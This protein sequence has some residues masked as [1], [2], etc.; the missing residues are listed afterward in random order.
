MR[1]LWFYLLAE[2]RTFV[3]R[4]AKLEAALEAEQA[5]NREREDLLVSR[6]LTAAGTYGMEPRKAP[7]QPF[8]PDAKKVPA[9]LSA[10]EEA[11]LEALRQAAI[12]AGRDESEADAF[13]WQERKF[14][15]LEV[16]QPPA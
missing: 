14:S 2:R 12:E 11:H 3:R 4:L 9:P 10:V 16:Y 5:R 1:R 15:N 7:F 6:V 13:F 8:S